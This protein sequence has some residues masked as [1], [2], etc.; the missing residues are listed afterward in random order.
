MALMPFAEK[1]LIAAGSNDPEIIP[2]GVILHVD[3]GNNESLFDF[4]KYR[5]GGIESHGH[6]QLNGHL[7]QYRDTERE[8]DANYKAN[9]FYGADGRRYGYI[10]IETQGWGDGEWTDAQIETIKQIL[11]WARETHGIP[12]IVCTSPTARGVGY[13]TLFGAP[14]AWT[15]VAKSCPGPRRK[16]QFHN[17]IVPWMQSGAEEDIMSDQQVT[18]LD[19]K[20]DKILAALGP[21]GV[22]RTKLK[23]VNTRLARSNNLSR[24]I[25]AD[26]ADAAET[27]LSAAQAKR[28]LAK[29]DALRADLEEGQ[30]DAATDD[31]EET[32]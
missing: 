28:L 23:R 4:F 17:I 13:H 1:K 25:R 24:E 14:S 12:L 5:S 15:P 2:I 7:E 31:T 18:Q 16:V 26:V 9:S 20:L 30:K 21:E 32:P 6:I 10:S 19:N 27:G 29:I 3:A 22:I 11:V 8:A